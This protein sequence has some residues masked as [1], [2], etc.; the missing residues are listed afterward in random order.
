M[1]EGAHENTAV[2]DGI[3]AALEKAEAEAELT[4][5]RYSPEEVLSNL[6]A[7]IASISQPD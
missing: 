6:R 5:K 4:D 2:E 1:N 7:V 3:H